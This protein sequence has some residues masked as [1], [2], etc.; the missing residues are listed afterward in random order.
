MAFCH[1]LAEPRR[2]GESKCHGFVKN[3]GHEGEDTVGRRVA[4]E[5]Y[6]RWR[7]MV[8]HKKLSKVEGESPSSTGMHDNTKT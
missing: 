3:G 7:Q 4:G 5:V 8:R 1:L 2:E 6:R